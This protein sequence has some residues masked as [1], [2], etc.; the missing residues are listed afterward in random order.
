MKASRT[1]DGHITIIPGNSYGTE[2]PEDGGWV[3]HDVKALSKEE[4]AIEIWIRLQ[5]P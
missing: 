1:L 4:L 2:D 3:Q 5:I